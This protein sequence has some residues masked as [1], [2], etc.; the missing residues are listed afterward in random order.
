MPTLE[1]TNVDPGDVESLVRREKI[2]K[3]GRK[4][5]LEA[6]LDSLAKWKSF[7]STR[8]GVVVCEL[9]D[10]MIEDLKLHLTMPIGMLRKSFNADGLPNMMSDD[11]EE[12][13]AECRGALSVWQ[14]IKFKSKELERRL[15]E[16]NEIKVKEEKRLGDEG[17]DESVLPNIIEKYA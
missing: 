17:V 3:R 4:K 14:N 10:P 16:F 6:L 5:E 12:Y 9:A 2:H 7:K 13:R 8:T 11:I 1:G 15:A